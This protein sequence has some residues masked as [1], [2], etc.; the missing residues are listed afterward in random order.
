L[1]GIARLE[2]LHGASR[3]S[4]QPL[5]GHELRQV[6]DNALVE[7]AS[8]PTETLAAVA[9]LSDGNPL[10]A[11]ELLKNA[12]EPRPAGSS[13]AGL[14]TSIRAAVLERLEP[15]SAA[16]FEILAQAAVIGRRFSAAVLEATLDAPREEVR[17]TLARARTLQLIVE[18]SSDDFRFRHA[19][20]R[21]A[22]YESFLGIQRRELHR[23]IALHLEAGRTE[24]GPLSRTG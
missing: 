8:L 3:I 22:I 4:L 24:A 1:R 14:P 21:E 12:L 11:E 10:F 20:T 16:E 7:P 15:L 9:Q 19:L 2:S 18:E 17:R 13:A 23:R 5:T 6:I